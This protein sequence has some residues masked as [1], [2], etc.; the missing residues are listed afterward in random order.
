MYNRPTK[1]LSQAPYRYL[2]LRVIDFR[3]FKSNG[4]SK[5]VYQ[6]LKK[7]PLITGRSRV[8]CTGVRNEEKSRGEE[9]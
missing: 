7:K 9:D 1:F 8:R 3:Q 5:K 2:H 4:P 6:K